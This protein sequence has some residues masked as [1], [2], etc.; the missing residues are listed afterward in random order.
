MASIATGPRPEVGGTGGR[1]G[2]SFL[3]TGLPYRMFGIASAGPH[4]AARARWMRCDTGR[5]S[6]GWRYRAAEAYAHDGTNAKSLV[7]KEHS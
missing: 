4:H 5:R 7:P 3:L 1:A 6:R 2:E